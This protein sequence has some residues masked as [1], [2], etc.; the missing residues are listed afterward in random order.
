[1]NQNDKDNNRIGAPIEIEPVSFRPGGRRRGRTTKS[2]SKAIG[3]GVLAT[4]LLFLA[5]SAWFVFTAR[6][7]N[8]RIEPRPERISIQGGIATFKFGNHYLLRP[9]DYTLK[10][11]LQCFQPLDKGFAVTDVKNQEVAFTMTRLPGRLSLE[12]HRAGRPLEALKGASILIDGRQVGLTPAAGLEV[13]AGRRSLAIRAD[14]YQ[15]LQTVLEVE[16]CG[17]QQ[18]LNV[19]LVPGWADISID[20]VPRGARLLVNGDPA[21]ATPLTIE[22]AAG[23]HEV[24]LTADRFKPWRD[25]LA[26][27]ANQHL[28]LDIIRL[29][30]ADGTL[31]VQTKPAGANVMV[32]SRFAGQ[33]PLDLNLAAETPH[34]V[35][36][37]KAGYQKAERTVQLASQE[38]KTLTVSL[39]PK[40]GTINFDVTPA[41]AEIVVDGKS[42]GRVPRQMRLIAVAHNI[43]LKKKGYRTY[44]TQ[45]IPRPGFT[46]EL[47]A[48]LIPIAP[49]VDKSPGAVIRAKNGYELK[50]VRPTAF[51]MGSSRREQG[52]RSNETLRRINLQR[53]FYMGLRE[54][55]NRE[56]RQY[57]SRHTSGKFKKYS[58]DHA[59]LPVV[60]IT[61]E[62]A[63]LFC[64]WLSAREALPPVYVLKGGRLAASDPVGTGYRLPTEAEWEYC[65]RFNNT[66]ANLKYPWGNKYPPGS[67]AGNFAD[68]S[69][70]D[71]LSS[72]IIAYH[73]GYPVAA[74]PA[75]FK[76][77]P[78][79]LYDLGGNVAEWCH[80]FYSM[81]SYDPQ[82]KYKDPTGP[83]DGKHHLIRGSSWRQSGISTLRSSY[84]DFGDGERV[85]LG[86]RVARYLE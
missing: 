80:D 3:G 9:G 86:F 29:Q 34:L 53:P 16:G 70:K 44:R 45:I 46:Q 67:L 55:T 52:R 23:R 12:A 68:E 83:A 17:V 66:N 26:V 84:R 38:S 31:T 78:L 81:Y 7:V 13:S 75:K 24:V 4:I 61:W 72:Y 73:D 48:A 65:T 62:Q 14:R 54:V 6:R 39:K 19:S 76:M 18:N 63:A 20:S 43:E 1:M 85:D 49:P 8:I 30:P 32:G 15:E 79:G 56:F 69:A 11:E 77:N 74:P 36:I 28:T 47:K 35:R 37:N 41:D 40:H 10:A 58:L 71:L 5:A 59:E 82:K 64:N 21:G 22:L 60:G 33:T 51:T 42:R 57:S 25:Q 50:L 27:E 2:R